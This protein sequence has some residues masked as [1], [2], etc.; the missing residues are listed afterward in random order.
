MMSRDT[1]RLPRG[2]RNNNPLNIR[3]SP[4]RFQGETEER[5][6]RSFK[7]FITMA[8]GFRAGYV[9]MRTYFRKY[10]LDT[11]EKIIR[12]WAPPSENDTN[13]YIH[14][15]CLHT[16]KMPTEPLYFEPGDMIPL[17]LAMAH[18]ENGEAANT[19]DAEEGWELI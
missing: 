14:F 9:I 8:Y 13:G 7:S 5:W 3:H 15:V 10:R 4:Q 17:V 2:F 6:D 18:F 11:T 19:A 1:E 12:R 16:G